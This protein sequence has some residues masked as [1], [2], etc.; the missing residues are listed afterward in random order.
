ML[1]WLARSPRDLFVSNSQCQDHK[2]GPRSL[3][4][5]LGPGDQ[6]QVCSRHFTNQALGSPRSPQGREQGPMH[7]RCPHLLEPQPTPGDVGN[8]E[9]EDDRS[10]GRNLPGKQA[11]SSR[12]LLPGTLW[13]E[14]SETWVTRGAL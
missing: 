2:G 4:F 11:R 13:L 1:G 14:E 7:P 5:Y 10:L 8:R 9:D 6:T 3:A 12:K